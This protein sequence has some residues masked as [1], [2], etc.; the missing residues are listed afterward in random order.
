MRRIIQNLIV[1][2]NISITI[3]LLIGLLK[4]TLKVRFFYALF[5]YGLIIRL[6]CIIESKLFPAKIN[7]N[8]TRSR[9][10]IALMLPIIG[11]S[12]YS[13][14]YTKSH[15]K[16]SNEQINSSFDYEELQYF[17]EGSEFFNNLYTTIEKSKK[18][19][20]IY[21]YIVK[22]D[23]LAEKFVKLL[24]KKHNEGIKVNVKVDAFGIFTS[25]STFYK[26]LKKAKINI[27]IVKKL[28]KFD[29]SSNYSFRTHKKYIII[30]NYIAYV[31]GMNL[32]QEYLGTSKKYGLWNDYMIKY[33]SKSLSK[34][35]IN[36]FLGQKNVDNKSLSNQIIIESAHNDSTN[37]YNAIIKNIKSAKEKIIIVTPYISLTDELNE[38]LKL[39]QYEVKIKFIVPGNH[40]GKFYANNVLKSYLS[41]FENIETYEIEN[42]FVHSKLFQ[43]DDEVLFGTVNF[44]MRSFFINDEILIKSKDKRVIKEINKLILKSKKVIYR[45]QKSIFKIFSD[46]I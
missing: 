37:I 45:K 31:G 29:L 3:A 46:S 28:N 38:L 11:P 32:A 15:Y 22:D 36:D 6:Y 9:K 27:K 18:E 44:D 13:S 19:I 41:N 17:N 14:T 7:N 34:I 26:K 20:W 4:W 2:I 10:M 30:D 24:I 39:R 21:F 1:Y 43:F 12:F 40:D 33:N 5:I 25:Y 35:L 23:D 8:T 16:Y 42:T